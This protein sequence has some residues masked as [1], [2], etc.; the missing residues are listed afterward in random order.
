MSNYS[1]IESAVRDLLVSEV[2]TLRTEECLIADLDGVMNSMFVNNQ[3][4][5]CVIDFGGWTS[6]PRRAQKNTKGAWIV[7][8]VFFI[9]YTDSGTPDA[10]AR[11]VAQVLRQ[12][13]DTDPRLDGTTPYAYCQSVGRSEPGKVNDIPFIMIPWFVEAYDVEVNL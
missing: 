12:F 3:N 13:V 8:G 10:D 2:S 7:E 9:R 6:Q 1:D 11:A 4:H 5:G